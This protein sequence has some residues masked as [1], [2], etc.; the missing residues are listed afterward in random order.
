VLKLLNSLLWL[1]SS[2]KTTTSIQLIDLL[3]KALEGNNVNWS[4][5]LYNQIHVDYNEFNTSSQIGIKH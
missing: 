1:Q 5:M 4:A 3:Q 2:T